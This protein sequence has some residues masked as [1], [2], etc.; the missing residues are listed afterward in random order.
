MI[1]L[2][3]IEPYGV[4]TEEDLIA[5]YERRMIN[6]IRMSRGWKPLKPFDIL[7]KWWP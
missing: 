1:F 3:Y 5:M 4:A 2:L 6:G 7:N